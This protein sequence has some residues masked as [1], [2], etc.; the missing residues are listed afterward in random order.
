MA[1]A[2]LYPK[3]RLSGAIGLE[4]TEFNNWFQSSSRSWSYGPGVSWNLFDAGA[5][6][7]NIEVQ[8][9][10]QEQALIQY[11]SVILSALEEVENALLSFVQE[12]LRRASLAAATEA[13]QSAVKLAQDQYTAGIVDFSTVLD[14]QRSLLSFQDQ[15]T[16]SEGAV[17]ADLVRFYKSVGGGWT[18]LLPTDAISDKNQKDAVK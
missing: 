16:Q 8:S 9:A 14:A 3:F 10:L 4:S 12:Q 15:L 17:T 7:Q 11:E 18:P 6:R 5:I 2:D 13:A 1:T